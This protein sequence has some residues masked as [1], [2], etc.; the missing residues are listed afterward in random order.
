M[1][2]KTHNGKLR[3]RQ[4]KKG[5]VL[6]S[7]SSRFFPVLQQRSLH[8]HFALGHC[9]LCIKP[10]SYKIAL[11]Q[12]TQCP[13]P[14]NSLHLKT[15]RGGA[16]TLHGYHTLF[17][18]F[19]IDQEALLLFYQGDCL[20]TYPLAFCTLY[21]CSYRRLHTWTYPFSH[22]NHEIF[23]FFTSPVWFIQTCFSY[24]ALLTLTYTNNITHQ[25]R[26][27]FDPTAQL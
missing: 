17:Q 18:L 13:S 10:F 19:I 8:F 25:T 7:I 9:S 21:S 14:Q 6:F 16:H 24:H 1:A 26:K 20:A 23:M 4:Q 11:L 27:S 2:K 22:L 15:I 5:K 3:E 12:A